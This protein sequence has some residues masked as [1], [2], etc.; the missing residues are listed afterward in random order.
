MQGALAREESRGAHAREDFPK[1]DDEQLDEAHAVLGRLRH[2]RGAGS[3][4][5]RCTTSPSPTRSPISSP[6]SGCIDGRSAASAF[7]GGVLP[8]V[9]CRAARVLRCSMPPGVIGL[10]PV[11]ADA[12][13]PYLSARSWHS[14]SRS[15]ARAP[16]FPATRVENGRRRDDRGP[17]RPDCARREQLAEHVFTPSKSNGFDS[18]IGLAKPALASI[19]H[20]RW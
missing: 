4:T 18:R 1:R 5:A 9:E 16:R 15:T 10:W 6:K 19:A 12:N 3:T 7:A 2:A 20:R 13:L 17:L 8:A 11:L 14:A